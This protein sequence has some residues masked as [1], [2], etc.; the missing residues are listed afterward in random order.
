MRHLDCGSEFLNYYF[1]DETEKSRID[2]TRSRSGKKNDNAFIAERTGHVVRKWIG[3]E[4]YD[5]KAHVAA[6]NAVYE[7]LDLYLNHFQAM[8][9]CVKRERVGA[10]YVRVYDAPQTPYARALAHKKIS[11]LQKEKLSA[12]HALLNPVTLL[13]EIAILKTALANVNRATKPT[14]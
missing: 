8:R 9:R 7:K 2:Q 12:Q 3:S 11:K 4:R 13:K 1:L 10:K 5:T 6:L 14:K